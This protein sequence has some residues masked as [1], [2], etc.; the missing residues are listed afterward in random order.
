MVNRSADRHDAIWE[1]P[2]T[3][4]PSSMVVSLAWFPRREW[5][6][7]TATWP[8]LLKDTP[9][10]SRRVQPPDRGPPQTPGSHPGRPP[11]SGCLPMT[12]DGLFEFCAED[13]EAPGTGEARS[14]YAADIVRRRAA[15]PWPPGRNAPLLV[16]FGSQGRDLL[17]A[18]PDRAGLSRP[19]IWARGGWV[20]TEGV[21]T[22]NHLQTKRAQLVV[23][24]GYEAGRPKHKGPGRRH[25]AGLADTGRDGAHQDLNL[26]LPDALAARRFPEAGRVGTSPFRRQWNFYRNFY[27]TG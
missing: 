16:R 21:N 8:D 6:K 4:V 15:L 12:V 3:Q 26:A 24:G 1:R 18:Y 25:N 20:H 17:R 13:G 19:M 2:P 22:A 5:E 9:G 23:T 14:S 11:P 27:R 7:A 10:R